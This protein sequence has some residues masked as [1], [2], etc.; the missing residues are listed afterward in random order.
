AGVAFALGGCVTVAT[1]NPQQ[2]IL[3]SDRVELP[4]LKGAGP[5]SIEAKINGVGPFRFVVDTGA[6]ILGISQRVADAAGIKAWENFVASIGNAAGET[7]PAKGG[8]VKSF[9]SAGLSLRGIGVIIAK[10]ADL[11]KM[12]AGSDAPHDGV[13]GM[14]ALRDV[15]LEIDFPQK[16]VTAVRPGTGNYP[17]NRSVAYREICPI[18]TLDV[19]GKSVNVLVDTGKDGGVGVPKLG[20]FPLLNGVRK[21]GGMAGA[22]FGQTTVQ[23]SNG[24]QLLGE[25]RVGP[26][27]L[28]NP[29]LDEDAGDVGSIGVAAFDSWKLV[30]DPRAKRIYFLGD[31]RV[32]NWSEQKPG[33]TRFEWGFYADIEGTGLRLLEVDAG[34]AS[35]LAGLRVG[36]LVTT[37]NDAPA[38][39]AAPGEL[40]RA[41]LHVRRE[42]SEFDVTLVTAPD[43]SPRQ[44]AFAAD[45]V[46]LPMAAG[47]RGA[48]V[49][50][51][52]VN[53]A[54]P[55][56]FLV[57]T[58][59]RALGV[60]S[61]VVEAAGLKEM[62]EWKVG[63]RA[64]TAKVVWVE[65]FAAGGLELKGL[66][67]TAADAAA[68][69]TV[70]ALFGPVDGFLGMEAVRDAT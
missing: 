15:V 56:R 43:Y 13:L 37:I 21:S 6:G 3:A 31:A 12:N 11:A 35:D 65:Q 62:P 34:S 42:N 40:N 19:A 69:A 27:V 36:D 70:S 52:R 67:A 7:V 51:A 64:A 68:L 5:L 8:W 4:T 50:E 66:A 38:V 32:V 44:T 54:G 2:T 61:R 57:G 58:R 29:P 41:R 33:D 46:A 28:R 48:L 47:S 26:V 39:R 55:F 53:G 20:E 23:R 1:F 18:V 9:D 45:R 59:Y 16:Q 30:F 22:V 49:V 25:V 24:G 63:G 17:V 14:E 60:S 10:D